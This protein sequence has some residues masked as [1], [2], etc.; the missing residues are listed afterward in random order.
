MAYLLQKM[1]IFVYDS[2]SV[3]ILAGSVFFLLVCFVLGFVFFPPL[4]VVSE[5]REEECI[6]FR[7]LFYTNISAIRKKVGVV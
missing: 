1:R 3:Q 7:S 6:Y 4:V 2:F 5:F